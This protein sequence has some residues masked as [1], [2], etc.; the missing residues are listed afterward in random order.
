MKKILFLDFDGVLFDT[1]KEVY[2]VNRYI[3]TG[4]DLFE[5]VEESSYKL[6]SKYKFLV[7]NIWMFFY[8]NHLLFSN[9][10]EDDII[11]QY[12]NLISNRNIKK[13]EEFCQ[14]FLQIRA[15]LIKNHYDFWQTLETPYQF[16]LDIKDF[17]DEEKIDIVVASKKNKS[18]ILKRFKEYNF[19]IDEN[20]VFARDELDKFSSKGEFFENYLEKNNYQKAIFVDDNINNINS[21]KDN[22]KIETILALWGNCEPKSQGYSEKEAIERIKNFFKS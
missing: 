10:K 12:K 3:K 6:F 21:C 2:L 8:Y 11:A 22:P 16:F 9:T 1:I 13:E 19:N 17:Y 15:D 18:S 5:P 4:I 7:Y 14:K 20:K